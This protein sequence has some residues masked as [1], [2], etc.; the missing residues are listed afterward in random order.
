MASVAVDASVLVAAVLNNGPDGDW[1]RSVTTEMHLIAPQLAP[2]EAGNVLQRAE[3]AR[4]ISRAVSHLRAADHGARPPGGAHR[5][6]NVAC[7]PRELA[8]RTLRARNSDR[9]TGRPH[10]SSRADSAGYRGVNAR[11][12]DRGQRIRTR[13]RPTCQGHARWRDGRQRRAKRCEDVV[14]QRGCYTGA[15]GGSHTGCSA[16]TRVDLVGGGRRNA[17][18]AVRGC[19]PGSSCRSKKS[20]S[21]NDDC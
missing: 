7:L 12:S 18:H 14:R 2:V 3:L 19:S 4:E 20:S 5:P 6:R 11:R 1:A 17:G 9:P 8:Q 16:R 21:S 15:T 10:V 13:R